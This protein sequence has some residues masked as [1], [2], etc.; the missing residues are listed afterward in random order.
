MLALEQSV[1]K[2]HFSAGAVGVI[3]PLRPPLATGL[4]AEHIGGPMSLTSLML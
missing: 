3:R 1:E 4:K 2:W